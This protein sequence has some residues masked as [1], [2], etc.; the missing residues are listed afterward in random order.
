MDLINQKLG[1][2]DLLREERQSFIEREDDSQFQLDANDPVHNGVG[3]GGGGG[4]YGFGG[5]MKISPPSSNQVHG[6]SIDINENHE[7]ED[8]LSS[9]S[10]E[11]LNART[12]NR[13]EYDRR[14][15]VFLGTQRPFQRRR[16]QE[17]QEI[18]TNFRWSMCLR[19]KHT[20]IFFACI[21]VF[22]IGIIVSL[23]LKN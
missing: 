15:S 5:H 6:Q 9:S 22:V 20:L 4:G 19:H 11:S 3:L 16:T 18:E 10:V 13:Q 23:F 8:S 14:L 17:E 7:R 1:Q 2:T 21:V 12:T